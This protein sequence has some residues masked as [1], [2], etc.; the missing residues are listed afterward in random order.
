MRKVFRDKRKIQDFSVEY[1][2]DPMPKSLVCGERV[3]A[4]EQVVKDNRVVK[5]RV[6][7]DID[8][9]DNFKDYKVSDFY[10][11]NLQATGAI[12]NLKQVQ[13][14]DNDIDPVLDVL[15]SLAGEDK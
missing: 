14:T 5:M 11:E 2:P 3:V 13:F 8:P 9:R 10:I 7:K 4:E 6:L 1:V 12:N 15:D